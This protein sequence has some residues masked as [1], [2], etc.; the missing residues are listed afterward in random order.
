MSI[1][2]QTARDE[3][4]GVAWVTHLNN[5]GAAL[6]PAPV[7]SAVTEHLELE[8]AI[9]GYE[10]A[11]ARRD[12]SEHSYDAIA[13]LI[14]ASR[15][16][17]AIV[18]NATRAW[19]MAF[20]SFAFEPG[21][22][23]LT[24]RAEYGSNYLAYLQVAQRTG[25]VVEVVPDDE[26][27]Q[28]SVDALA[29]MLDERVKLVSVTHVPTNGG[30]VNPIEAI[31]RL[32][33]AAG[34]PYLVDACQSAGQLPLDVEAIGCDLLAVTGRKFL[35]AP[36]GTGFLYARNSIVE[37][38]QPPFVDIRSATWETA[39]SYSLMP[40]ARR[41]ETWETNHA[42]KI[43]LGVAVDY[44]LRWGLEEI[45]DANAAL[46]G[47]L[48]GALGELEGATVLDLGVDPCAIV[49]FALAGQDPEDVA[50]RLRE[51]GVNISVSGVG[52]TRLDM[53]SRGYDRWLRASVHYYNSPDEVDWLVD[54]LRRLVDAGT[55]SRAAT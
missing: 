35:R 19:D 42:T 51:R 52:D 26:T 34:I 6:M 11:D 40:D 49:S 3:T 4:L 54:E 15:E 39:D 21:D 5:A 25:A 27:G 9:G 53:E 12:W 7:V 48:R 30:L 16:E 29:E 45:R 38:L 41:F 8:A 20:Y 37:R 2:L 50:A 47:R 43:A 18:E 31:G 23:I 36:R 1:D 32:T 24:A 14:G 33:R 17:I 44:A 28:L 13:R 10:A 55:W 22:R 46:A